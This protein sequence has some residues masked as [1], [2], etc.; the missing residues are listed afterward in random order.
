MKKIKKRSYG[1]IVWGFLTLV[2]ATYMVVVLVFSS[3]Q[4]S[5]ENVEHV[6]E[7]F[8]GSLFTT[9]PKIQDATFDQW[10]TLKCQ[11]MRWEID[12]LFEESKICQEESDCIVENKWM[13]CPFGCYQIH[14]KAYDI[15]QIMEKV[16]RLQESKCFLCEY[17]CTTPPTQED[18][19]CLKN[20]CV[21]TRYEM[22]K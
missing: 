8:T 14:N 5:K 20:R 16:I 4:D 12:S 2:L 21:D 11:K 13:F 3:N 22:M 1:V 17:K 7:L 19:K 9:S 15:S 10:D 6:P 18:L